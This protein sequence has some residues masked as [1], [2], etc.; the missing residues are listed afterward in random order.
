VDKSALDA[1][2]PG[3]VDEGIEA[4]LSANGRIWIE[5]GKEG[6]ATLLTAIPVN[7]S[8]FLSWNQHVIKFPPHAG[9]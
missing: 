1:A 5:V 6:R 2:R 7:E 9:S 8:V 4:V 3:S